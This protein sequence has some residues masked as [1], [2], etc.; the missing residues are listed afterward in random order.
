[1]VNEAVR[2]Y[3]YLFLWFT[4]QHRTQEMCSGVGHMEPYTLDHVPCH[5]TTREICNEIMCIRSGAFSI[6][7]DRFKI[8][9]MCSKAVEEEPWQLHHDP[10]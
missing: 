6:I 2:W 3:P 7:P 1:M 5:L 9:E 10:N 8:Q 4:D